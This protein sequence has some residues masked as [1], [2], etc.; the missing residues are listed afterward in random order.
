GHCNLI[1]IYNQYIYAA[2]PNNNTV[3]VYRTSDDT[4]VTVISVDTG[5]SA[6]EM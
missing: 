1:N 2:Q 6:I 3:T 5:P 4:A